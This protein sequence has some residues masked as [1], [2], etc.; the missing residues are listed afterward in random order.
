MMKDISKWEAMPTKN[1]SLSYDREIRKT[2]ALN[3]KG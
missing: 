2:N 3:L 1:V